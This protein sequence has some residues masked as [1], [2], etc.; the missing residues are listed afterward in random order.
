MVPHPTPPPLP[1]HNPPTPFLFPPTL[2][3]SKAWPP[4]LD[5][6]SSTHLHVLYKAAPASSM[7]NESQTEWLLPLFLYKRGENKNSRSPS[8]FL[9][10]MYLP[11]SFD[12]THNN[13]PSS[14]PRDCCCQV[15]SDIAAAASPLCVGAS[16]P[17][18]VAGQ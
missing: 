8:V 4:L 18:S 16:L 11:R 13:T 6:V 10:V 3:L 2:C 1:N 12:C 17:I 5:N 14:L 15:T 7:G 9:S